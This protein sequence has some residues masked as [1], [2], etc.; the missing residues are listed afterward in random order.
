MT[1]SKYRKYNSAIKK[2]Y[3]IPRDLQWRS[4]KSVYEISKDFFNK[5]DISFKA[6]DL[7]GYPYIYSIN[8]LNDVSNKAG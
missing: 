1:P 4:N 6:R 2:I 8:D 3:T 7:N 5:N